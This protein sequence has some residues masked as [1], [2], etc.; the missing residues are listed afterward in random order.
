MADA[1][2]DQNAAALDETEAHALLPLLPDGAGVAEAPPLTDDE[3]DALELSD[4]EAMPTADTELNGQL[5]AAAEMHWVDVKL[6]CVSPAVG[7]TDSKYDG[8]TKELRDGVAS[9][10]SEA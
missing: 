2:G 6:R 9:T 10:L 5:L 4:G 7:D 3:P 8:V 1:D